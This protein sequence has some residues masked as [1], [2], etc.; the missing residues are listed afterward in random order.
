[1]VCPVVIST[2]KNEA[3]NETKQW[4]LWG[5]ISWRGVSSI[6]THALHLLM[7][8]TMTSLWVSLK[9]QEIALAVF[10]KHYS[11]LNKHYSL[12]LC[13]FI[14]VYP[15]SPSSTCILSRKPSLIP[16]SPNKLS[17]LPTPLYLTWTSFLILTAFYAWTYMSCPASS[18]CAGSVYS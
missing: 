8:L 17:Q 14:S 4:H 13:S 12:Y 18:V 5:A 1:M 7:S 10:N 16:I 2:W 15:P 9:T 11:F 3:A 6:C